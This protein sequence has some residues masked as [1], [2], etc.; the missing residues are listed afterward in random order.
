MGSEN[1]FIVLYVKYDY[2][3]CRKEKVQL[4]STEANKYIA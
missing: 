3:T 4:G 2:H 1:G